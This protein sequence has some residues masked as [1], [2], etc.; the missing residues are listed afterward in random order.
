M[1]N[2]HARC[3]GFEHSSPKEYP[4]VVG[5]GANLAGFDHQVVIESTPNGESGYF[6]EE[7]QAALSGQSVFR[8]TVLY[9]WEEPDNQLPPGAEVLEG[10]FNDAVN[11]VRKVK[12][13]FGE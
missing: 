1:C 4:R 6:Y 7:V 10:G 9:W 3:I 11:G 5:G 12:C 13:G 2:Y 8:L